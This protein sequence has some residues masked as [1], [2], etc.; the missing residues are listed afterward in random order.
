[1]TKVYVL[2]RTAWDSH[3][4]N[5]GDTEV[6]IFNV[7]TTRAAAEAAAATLDLDEYS[8]MSATAHVEERDLIS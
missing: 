6:T 1:M 4:T 2:V 7:Y 8:N 5:A 3:L